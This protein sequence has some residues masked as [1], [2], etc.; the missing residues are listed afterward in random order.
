MLVR[1]QA[2]ALSIVMAGISLSLLFL[3]RD[4]HSPAARTDPEKISLQNQ[5]KT[6]TERVRLLE[7]EREELLRRESENKTSPLATIPVAE[8]TPAPEPRLKESRPQDLSAQSAQFWAK[9]RLHGIEEFFAL[10][11]EERERVKQGLETEYQ[12]ADR[13]L[14]RALKDLL[15]EKK[16]DEFSKLRR[17]REQADEKED[18]ESEVFTLSRKLSL[19]PAEE[20]VVSAALVS[21]NSDLAA[22]RR[23]IHDVSADAVALHAAPGDNRP[24]L[25]ESYKELSRIAREEAAQ[26]K[27]LVV[28]KL[29]GKLSDD[30]LNRLLEYQASQH[31]PFLGGTQD[32]A[33]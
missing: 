14:D 4:E 28:S 22:L 15:G 32:Q 25:Q 21:V 31:D 6:L 5:V 24:A 3:M 30:Q 33:E 26:R 9:N 20:Q 1:R 13:N 27:E 7:S 12:K 18:L 10:N 17:E 16:Y 29:R 23:Q 2:T 19:T 11:A 8:T